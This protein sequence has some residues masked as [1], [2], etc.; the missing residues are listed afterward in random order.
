[1]KI[2][3]YP[4]LKAVFAIL[5]SMIFMTTPAYAQV[6]EIQRDGSILVRSD[7]PDIVWT[8]FEQQLLAVSAQGEDVLKPLSPSIVSVIE[9][10][11]VP[12]GWSKAL[13]VVAARYDLSPALIEALVWQESRWRTG[14]VSK[15][16][17][18]GLTQLMPGTARSL[19]VDAYDPVANLDGGARYLRMQLNSFNGNVDHALAAYNAGPGR[20]IAAGG[21]PNIAETRAYVM[22]ITNRLA[23]RALTSR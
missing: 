3:L 1:M 13:D 14:A 8:A 21:I 6:M 2:A 9:T 10:P 20:V 4:P 18:R 7:A 23:A 15:A 22:A 16:G 12:S 11:P 19:R 5:N 17:A